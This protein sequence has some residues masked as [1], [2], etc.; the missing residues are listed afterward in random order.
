[1]ALQVVKADPDLGS[2]VDTIAPTEMAAGDRSCALPSQI[3]LAIQTDVAAF[4]AVVSMPADLK[5]MTDAV[6][7]WNG[8]WSSPASSSVVD[9]VLPIRQAVVRAIEAAPLACQLASISGPI[10]IPISDRGHI[11]TVIF[12]SGIW[13]W[14]DLVQPHTEMETKNAILNSEIQKQ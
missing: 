1:M 11:A 4:Q 14:A 7:L 13:R 2:T 5:S 12:G 9:H 8:Q 6:M 10:F 3:A